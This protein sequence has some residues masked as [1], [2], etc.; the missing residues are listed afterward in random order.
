M[1]ANKTMRDVN[2]MFVGLEPQ[3]VVESDSQVPPT[4]VIESTKT[5]DRPGRQ[6]IF[7]EGAPTKFVNVQLLESE[8]AFLQKYSG[9]Y[10]GKTG[11]VRKLV[12]DEMARVLG[13]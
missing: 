3:K 4:E 7:P 12:Q 8:V 6:R 10:G 11:Y 13:E 9:E 2:R 5:K 1:A